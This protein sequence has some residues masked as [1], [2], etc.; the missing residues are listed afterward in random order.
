MAANQLTTTTSSEDQATTQNPQLAG[1]PAT[2][3]AQS[4]S[5]QPGTATDL[6]SSRGGVPLQEKVLP[7]VN[8]GATTSSV[9]VRPEPRPEPKPVAKHHVSVVLFGLPVLLVLVAIALLW[10]V[11]RS[12]KNPT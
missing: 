4:S 2:N 12:A 9:A 6:L 10:A 11:R 8:L 5:V 7:S 3:G 1:Q